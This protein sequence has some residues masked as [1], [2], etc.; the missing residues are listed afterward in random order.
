MHAFSSQAGR[1]A[2]DALCIR[3]QQEGARTQV[4]L[5]VEAQRLAHGGGAVG[6]GIQ[7]QLA[8]RLGH[9]AQALQGGPQPA[10]QS[11]QQPGMRRGGSR[12]KG[13]HSSA[14][15]GLNNPCP[16][17]RASAIPCP[18]A[19][20]P[21]RLPLPASQPTLPAHLSALPTSEKPPAFCQAVSSCSTAMH[22]CRW[23]A[24]VQ[25]GKAGGRVDE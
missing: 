14:P 18:P 1:Q 25:G 6:I 16:M 21:A 12:C 20:P 3:A 5:G 24:T 17:P 23:E 4:A 8:V 15:A 19:H 11:G 13:A 9:A 7:H 2:A 22:S 10:Q